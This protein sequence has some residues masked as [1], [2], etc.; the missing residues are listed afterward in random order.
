MSEVSSESLAVLYVDGDNFKR[1]NDQFGHDV[2]DEFIIQFGK[3]LMKSVRANDLVVRMGGDEFAIVLTG[4]VR[5]KIKRKH[6]VKHIIGRINENLKQG[7]LISKQTFAPTASIGVAF[8]PD[9]GASLEKLLSSSDK[10]LYNAKTTSIKNYT[11][12]T[13][14]LL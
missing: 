4:L 8:Y 6:Q 12:Y 13:P 9:H 10:A 2:G 3:A 14:E 7:W 1:V 5:D 11:I